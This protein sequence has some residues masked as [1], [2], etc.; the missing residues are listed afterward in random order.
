MPDGPPRT[1]SHILHNL[2]HQ[3]NILPPVT[4]ISKDRKPTSPHLTILSSPPLQT[5]KLKDHDPDLVTK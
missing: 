3:I 1:T 5:Q 2:P 4:H